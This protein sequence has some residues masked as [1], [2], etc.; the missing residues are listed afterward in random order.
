LKPPAAPF[1]LLDPCAGEGRAV[2]QLASLLGCQPGMV[3]AIELEEG[4]AQTLRAA[5][6]EANILAPA[7][8]FGCSA[9]LGSFSLVYLNPPF[10]DHYG[11]GRGEYEWLSKATHLLQ[12]GGVMVLVCPERV[13][14]DR[15][16]LQILLTSWYRDVNVVPFPP[17][18]RQFDE[19]FVLAVKLQ[20]PAFDDR[21]SSY[22][23]PEFDSVKAPHDWTY[24]VPPGATP[25]SFAKVE[26][27]EEELSRA[28]AGS[29]LRS[30]L[31]T[32]PAPSIPS[33]PLALGT[34]HV[35]LLLASGYLDG[36]VK[37]AGE[38]PHLVRGTSRKI[39]YVA[40]TEDKVNDKGEVTGKVT[41]YKERI[42][43]VVR[44]VD[45][46]GKITTF[47]DGSDVKPV[48]PEEDSDV[49]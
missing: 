25:R 47:T 4:R 6:P 40:S 34:G 28:L 41:I 31:K 23:R 36:V 38:A 42:Q 27:T 17:S 10:D 29:P 33:P 8:F 7:S 22:N 1:S 30:R 9:T 16:G 32:A 12:P 43:L 3:H 44:A 21:T 11:G 5:L 37:P 14:A 35:A 19:V 15:W 45:L 26:P 18:C 39:K 20:K 2:G 24:P 46:K 48:N 13:V 49:A